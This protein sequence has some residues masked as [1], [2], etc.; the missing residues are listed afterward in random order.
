MK[1]YY[2]LATVFA[3]MVI[4]ISV[5]PG[6][7][8]PQEKNTVETLLQERT[9]IMQKAFYNQ[10]SKEKAEKA[11]AEIETYPIITDDIRHLRAWENTEI[12][13][14]KKMSFPKVIPEKNMFEYMTY[15]V[16]ILWEMRGL[17]GDY[18]MEGDYHVVL[19]K[20]NEQYKISSFTPV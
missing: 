4:V 19:K 8:K 17:N 11:L 10:M 9:S 14:V 13:I 2:N 18:F 3:I 1:K 15:R 5:F 6:F 12:D 16:S 7:S 20:I